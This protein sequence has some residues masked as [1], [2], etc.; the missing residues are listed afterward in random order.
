MIIEETFTID[1]P[2]QKVWDFFLDIDQMSKCVPGAEVKQL[3]ADNYEGT[4]TVKVG[5]IGA[6]FSGNVIITKQ[7]PPTSIEA[8]V[9]GKDKLTGSMVQGK[10][11]STLKAAS[12]AQTEVSYLI[13]VTIRGKL[14]QFGQTIIQ[15]TSKRISA[16][17]LACVKAQI[18][19]P[20]GETAPP[21]MTMGEAGN[22]AGKAFLDA[23]FNAIRNWFA[24]L[25][26]RSQ[27]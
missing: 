9:K 4:L 11:S 12:P 8:A 13:D 6:S 19:T 21:P 15:D 26:K 10:F 22:V 23:F 18:E 3:D 14:G 25:F 20:E 24:R 17:F 2:A 1:A 5:P 7:T 27:S 16:E